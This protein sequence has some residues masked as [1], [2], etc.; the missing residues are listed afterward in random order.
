[1]GRTNA[2]VF[3]CDSTND[4]F[5]PSAFEA[6]HLKQPHSTGFHVLIAQNAHEVAK[7]TA[8]ASKLSNMQTQYT[9]VGLLAM[10]V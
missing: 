10:L 5:A 7:V 2:T 9:Q 6:C 4:P 3:R 1:M 8:S